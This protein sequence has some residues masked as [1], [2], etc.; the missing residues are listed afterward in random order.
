MGGFCA[1]REAAYDSARWAILRATS[2]SRPFHRAWLRVSAGARGTPRTRT[3]QTLMT[4]LI[5]GSGLGD[6][7]P[8]SE[9]GSEIS[10]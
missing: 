8:P 6:Y 1:G 3:S 5:L 10:P 4:V 2:F 9:E 7:H